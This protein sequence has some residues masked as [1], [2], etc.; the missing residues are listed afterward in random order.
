[1][2][3]TGTIMYLLAVAAAPLL[4]WSVANVV[5]LVG[6]LMVACSMY[7]GLPAI[8]WVGVAH[9]IV[10]V[11]G[12]AICLIALALQTPGGIPSIVRTAADAGKFSLGSLDLSFANDAVW[13]V[14]AYGL[15][16]NLGNFA[17]DQGY[18][19]RYQ[20]VRGER[21]AQASTLWGAC[22]Y[23]PVAAVFFFIGTSLW[24]YVQSGAIGSAAGSI[25]SKS[26]DVFPWYISTQL[27]AGLAG[28][29]VAGVFAAALDPSLNSMAVLSLDDLYRRLWRPLAGERE[30]LWVL[31]LATLGW[32]A[33]SVAVGLAMIQAEQVLDVW[34]KLAGALGGGTLGLFLLGRMTRA[35]SRQALAAVAVGLA[36]IL[37]MELSRDPQQPGEWWRNPFP[38][39]MTDVFGS[40]AIWIVGA[41][42]SLL[43]RP[44][45]RVAGSASDRGS[46]G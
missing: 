26:D 41:V 8:V 20:S 10:I 11:A 6:G 29:V 31:R 46:A 18:I 25:P 24:V 19:Q 30:S 21:A 34:W 9:G 7:G 32:G 37:W 22:L 35:T 4:G 27:P 17:V 39:L 12:P 36:V 44:S 2:A 38:P 28:I 13:I 33:L 14:L 45:R 23:V 3:R 16:I 42:L 43:S 1:M 40:A 15:V 5:L